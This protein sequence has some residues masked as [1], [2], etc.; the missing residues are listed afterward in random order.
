M[1]RP[2]KERYP[3]NWL[4]A[5]AVCL[6]GISMLVYFFSSYTVKN[7]FIFLTQAFNKTISIILR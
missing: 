4:G 5:I 7:Y 1:P 3:T 6:S 2:D